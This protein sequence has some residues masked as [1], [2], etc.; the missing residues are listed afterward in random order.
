[1]VR[2]WYFECSGLGSV[3]DVGNEILNQTTAHSAPPPCKVSYKAI[4]K[5]FL[6]GVDLS[7]S[8]ILSPTLFNFNFFLSSFIKFFIWTLMVLLAI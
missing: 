8:L 7:N 2:T 4:C 3:P 5:A 1:M 6:C